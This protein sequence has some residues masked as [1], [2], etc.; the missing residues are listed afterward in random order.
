MNRPGVLVWRSHCSEPHL[1]VEMQLVGRD[2]GRHLLEVYGDTTIA[3]FSPVRIAIRKLS[4]GSL[5]NDDIQFS[6]D[7]AKS[8]V[9]VHQ[10]KRIERGVHYLLATDQVQHRLN[11][12]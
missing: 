9:G 10:F 1:P 4:N 3:I 11:A 8:A 2:D 5:K 12:Q 6:A 7:T